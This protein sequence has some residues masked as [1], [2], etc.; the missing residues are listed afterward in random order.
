MDTEALANFGRYGPD[1]LSELY[2]NDPALFDELAAALISQ[3]CIGH[4]EEESLLLRQMQWVIDGQLRKGK[5]KLQRMHIME[6][7]FYSR[8]FGDDGELAHLAQTWN[9]L[10]GD[11]RRFERIG[12]E[13]TLTTL[14]LSGETDKNRHQPPR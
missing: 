4:T 13:K 9:D 3:A 10:L 7:I 14:K 5:T 8:T 12:M 11:L 6:N 2:K 1:E